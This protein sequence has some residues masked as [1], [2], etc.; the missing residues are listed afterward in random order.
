[1]TP[2]RCPRDGFGLYSDGENRRY[3]S[4]PDCGWGI[5]SC[6]RCRKALVS[7][8]SEI[9][10]SC[11]E[12]SPAAPPPWPSKTPPVCLT[13][14]PF[15]KEAAS[16]RRAARTVP[17]RTVPIRPVAR[18]PREGFPWFAAFMGIAVT[19]AIIS[20]FVKLEETPVSSSSPQAG[21]QED[22]SPATPELKLPLPEP[23]P[24]P[25]DPKLLAA[26]AHNAAREK[27]WRDAVSLFQ[28]VLTLEP[29][30]K[31]AGNSLEIARKALAEEE[32]LAR[33]EEA[34]RKNREWVTR[35][36]GLRSS[37]ARAEKNADFEA[38]R[39]YARQILEI[40][41]NDLLARAFRE[42]DLEETRARSEQLISDRDE[43]GVT[44]LWESYEQTWPDDTRASEER[45]RALQKLERL[46]KKPSSEPSS[47]SS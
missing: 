28:R 47:K 18:R 16:E 30:N 17:I 40:V 21:Q 24:T 4:N 22:P 38:G 2:A 31:E 43:W 36:Q 9:C 20:L 42:R 3:C 19:A 29:A 12:S 41:P 26:S 7:T 14:P 32:L 15:P 35:V 46:K 6:A 10:P 27:R 33:G 1:M 25:E 37:L 23:S 8:P 5:I 11:L 45:S 13:P 39:V 34:A 44:H